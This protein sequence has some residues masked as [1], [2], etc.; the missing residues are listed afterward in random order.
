MTLNVVFHGGKIAYYFIR[1]A[2]IP[3]D[4]KITG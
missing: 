1:L 3:E 2:E 4:S